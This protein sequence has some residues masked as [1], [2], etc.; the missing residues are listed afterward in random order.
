[1]FLQLNSRSMF[2]VQGSMFDACSRRKSEFDV[3][4]FHLSCRVRLAVFSWP[5]TW[6]SFTWLAAP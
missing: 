6:R 4:L 5:V 3:S 2:N 1:M